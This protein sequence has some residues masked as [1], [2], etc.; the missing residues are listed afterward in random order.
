VG[1]LFSVGAEKGTKEN[2][3][4]EKS[5]NGLVRTPHC[6]VEKVKIEEMEK[7]ENCER[8]SC[9]GSGKEKRKRR[10]RKKK[11]KSNWVREPFLSSFSFF[12]PPR[13]TREKFSE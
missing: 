11:K 3:D 4:R 12:V 6:A 5:G 7:Q 9:G 13:L 1:A 2:G 8:A 10:G